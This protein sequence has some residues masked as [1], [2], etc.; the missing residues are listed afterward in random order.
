MQKYN[1]FISYRGSSSGGLLGKE[2]YTDLRHCKNEDNGE[3]ITPF[4]A[5]ACIERGENFKQVITEVLKN[6]SCVILILS[7]RFFESC[8][9][10]DD[11]VFYELKESLKN[12]NISFIPIVMEGFTFDTELKSVEYLFTEDEIT[13]FKHINAINHH[14][15][16]DFNTEVDVLPAIKKALEKKSYIENAA[17]VVK[18]DL[19]KFS[20]ISNPRSV[21]FGR[22]PQTILKDEDMVHKIYEGLATGVTK[23]K[24]S[25]Y[26]F[27]GKTYYN[28]CENKFNKRTF[29]NERADGSYSFYVVEPIIWLEIYTNEQYSVLITK[30]IIDATM[31]NLDRNPH[32]NIESNQYRL[33]NDWEVSYIR[34][35]LNSEFYYDA[36]S[37]KERSFIQNSLI[38]N[39]SQS[40][41]YETANKPDTKDRVFLIS[42]KEIYIVGNGCAKVSDYARARGAYASTSATCDKYGDWWTRSPGNIPSSVENVDR[43]G[44]LDAP[45]FCNY[46]N[47]TSAGVRPCILIKKDALNN[48]N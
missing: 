45:P 2:I 46:V 20:E 25:Q 44:C 43:R 36:F 1:V 9:E 26:E 32:R 38:E 12:P 8:K 22:Y 3:F 48:G 15:I 13:R 5:P 14:G 47:D 23:K 35:W 21:N 41:Y 16:Y 29:E 19:N 17:E 34:R 4:F 6:V 40:S 33:P 39:S 42:H 37:E 18:F 24:E 27:S 10:P 30:D 31:F 28:I 11:M 7:P